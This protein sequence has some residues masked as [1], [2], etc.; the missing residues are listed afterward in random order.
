MGKKKKTKETRIED[1]PLE[2]EAAPKSKSK[3]KVK[4]PEPALPP[5]AE[6]GI[7]KFD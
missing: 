3:A 2:T 6:E 1:V 5:E 4:K 7:V